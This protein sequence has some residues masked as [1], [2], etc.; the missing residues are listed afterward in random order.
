MTEHSKTQS[1]AP[2]PPF[3]P[4]LVRQLLDPTSRAALF[5]RAKELRQAKAQPQT[6]DEEKRAPLKAA[7]AKELTRER[8]Q[9]AKVAQSKSS[10]ATA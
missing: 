6:L 3:R 9:A 8:N 10:G 5:K 1:T 7:A 4:Q 2:H